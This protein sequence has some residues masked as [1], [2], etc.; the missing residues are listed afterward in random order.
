MNEDSYGRNGEGGFTLLEVMISLA[1]LAGVVVTVLATMSYHLGVA[2]AD[3]DLVMASL[4]GRTKVEEMA[5]SPVPAGGEG[6]FA[7]PD[8]RFGWSIEVQDTELPELKRV[9]LKVTWEDDREVD[10]ISYRRTD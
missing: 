2:A 8:R 5:F 9:E 7:G 10:F 6:E 1:V 3:R 4:L